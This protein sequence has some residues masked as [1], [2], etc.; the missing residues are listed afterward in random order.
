[1]SK[2]T[3]PK[4][5]TMPEEIPQAEREV[6]I[7][8][9]QSLDTLAKKINFSASFWKQTPAGEQ[10]ERLMNEQMEYEKRWNL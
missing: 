8:R 9:C 5:A 4:E 6:A 3:P 10:Y 1:M 2:I 7:I